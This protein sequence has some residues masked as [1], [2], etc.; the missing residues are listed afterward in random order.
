MADINRFTKVKLT[1]YILDADN[2]EGI[3]EQYEES[4]DNIADIVYDALDAMSTSGIFFI[5]KVWCEDELNVS[6]E[7]AGSILYDWLSE[8]DALYDDPDDVFYAVNII[9]LCDAAS[10]S[11]AAKKV[12][13]ACGFDFDKDDD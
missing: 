7:E 13:K 4:P 8:E 6:D 12:R 11:E 5:P 1:N 2:I 9:E 3:V 10:N